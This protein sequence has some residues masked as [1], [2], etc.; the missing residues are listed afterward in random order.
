MT[1]F[2]PWMKP[3]LPHELSSSAMQWKSINAMV[4]AGELHNSA[5]PHS[6]PGLKSVGSGTDGADLFTLPALW[7]QPSSLHP[8]A[9]FTNWSLIGSSDGSL[10]TLCKDSSNH[11]KSS[12]Q[13]LSEPGSSHAKYQ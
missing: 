4:L 12:P 2:K 5:L 8:Q 3:G 11:I 10:Q 9:L 7:M 1:L 13:T 6:L